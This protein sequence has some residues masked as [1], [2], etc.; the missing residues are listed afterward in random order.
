MFEKIIGHENEKTEILVHMKNNSLSHAYILYGIEGIG[1]YTFAVEFAK[2]ILC[3]TS[4]IYCSNCSSC[5]LCDANTHPDFKILSDNK[6]IGVKEIKSL[7]EFVNTKSIL[8]SYKVIIIDQAEKMTVAA[9]NKFLKTFENPP[10]NVIIILIVNNYDLIIDTIKS[11]GYEI[12][13]KPLSAKE[14]TEYL[15]KKTDIDKNY[16]LK[17]SKFFQGSILKANE[18]ILSDD[19]KY[20]VSFPEQI[21]NSI[22]AKDETN[23]IKL[24][25]ELNSKTNKIQDTLE[26]ILMWIR[27]I[28]IYK[29]SKEDSALLFSEQADIIKRHS[30]YFSTNILHEFSKEIENTKIIINNNVNKIV[31]LNYC[32][33]KIQEDYNEFS[34]RN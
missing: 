26:Y 25:R 14:I 16:L 33:L 13:F 22:I 20:I 18:L 28:S 6:T 29:I 17:T 34:D 21:F 31:A 12:Y 8:S 30:N 1:K 24:I 9:Q 7:G 23:L 11:R 10:K 19:F 4:D 15:I 27:D 2:S 5:T 32:L 3:N